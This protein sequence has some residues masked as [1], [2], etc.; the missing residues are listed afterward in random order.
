MSETRFLTGK[1][2]PC[3]ITIA[4]NR[5]NNRRGQ[6]NGRWL[7]RVHDLLCSEQGEN[8]R[9]GETRSGQGRNDLSFHQD[10]WGSL[11]TQEQVLAEKR[12]FLLDRKKNVFLALEGEQ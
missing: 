12:T 8:W 11:L 4:T 7:N 9:M 2:R 10:K 1:E 6:V 5:L 3:E